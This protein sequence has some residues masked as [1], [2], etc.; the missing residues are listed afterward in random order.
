M[1][2]EWN[3]STLYYRR[4]GN[5]RHA[6]LLFHGFGQDSSVFDGVAAHFAS[7]AVFFSFDLFFHGNSTWHNGEKPVR[8]GDWKE[9][10]ARFLE[11]EKVTTFSLVGYSIGARFAL[12]TLEAFPRAVSKIWMIA[13]DGITDHPAYTLAV[14]SRPGQWL[15]RRLTHQPAWASSFVNVLKKVSLIPRH[16]VLMADRQLRDRTAR[17][18]L[19]MTWMICRRLTYAP[20]QLAKLI[21]THNVECII[22]LSTRDYL[23]RKKGIQKLAGTA[24]QVRV[25]YQT[26]DH[27]RLLRVLKDYVGFD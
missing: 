6:V 18:K 4:Q 12:A 19:F 9:L 23:V 10:M 13:P 2:I 5:G 8:K 16:A 22:V 1:E 26:E 27:H 3:G 7:S 15:F 21:A 11:T 14:G 24:P 17:R 20:D 25:I